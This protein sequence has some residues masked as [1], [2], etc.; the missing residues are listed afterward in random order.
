MV[1]DPDGALNDQND[2]KDGIG[3]EAGD[4]DKTIRSRRYGGTLRQ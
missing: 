3:L 4:Y 1:D 2:T